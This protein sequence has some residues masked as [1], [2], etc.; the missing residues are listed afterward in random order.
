MPI[1][2]ARLEI[3]PPLISICERFNLRYYPNRHNGDFRVYIDDPETLK[4]FLTAVDDFENYAV[5]EK[6]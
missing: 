2:N 1:T 3:S 5:P 4:W 6:D